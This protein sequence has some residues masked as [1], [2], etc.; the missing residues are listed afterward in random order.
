L[1]LGI[2]NPI[3]HENG[4]QF[5]TVVKE[6]MLQ[7]SSKSLEQKEICLVRSIFHW[8]P[9]MGMLCVWAIFWYRVLFESTY[10]YPQQ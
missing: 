3:S 4:V 1:E 9:F 5:V 10:E 8:L 6:N 7:N 2:N